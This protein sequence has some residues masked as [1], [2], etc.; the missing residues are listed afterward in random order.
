[1]KKLNYFLLILLISTSACRKT[2]K[3]EPGDNRIPT[4]PK[5]EQS[6]TADSSKLL[7]NEH[8]VLGTLYHQISAEYRAA[9]I[10]AYNLAKLMLDKDL[11]D[12]QID[13]HRV[14][15]LD[16]DETVLDNSPYQAQC[17]LQN[18]SYPRRWDEW[19]N[20]AVAEAVPGAL[21]FTK[22]AR[23]NGVSVFY[24]T[25]RKQHLKEAT[26][27]NLN[28]L[29]FPHADDEHVIMRTDESSKEGRRKALSEK[30]HIAL[31]CG[32]NLNDFSHDFEKTN[33]KE[34]LS[35]LQDNE[36]EFGNR[37]IVLPNSLYGEWES[38]L[39]KQSTSPAS[40]SLNRLARLKALKGF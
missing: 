31:F 26:I 20:K 22:Y 12:K 27:K 36:K 17:I 21:E 32:D 39:Y 29:G 38:T 3:T 2:P 9:C 40:D 28:R 18:I 25:N 30:Y 5:I 23:G 6:T 13:K 37:F 33:N 35:A 8:M 34:R 14:V 15:V 16:I 10:Q 4:K 11:Q 1:M 19:C 24:I 7:H